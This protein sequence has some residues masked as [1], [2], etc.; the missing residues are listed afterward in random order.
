[1][2]GGGGSSSTSTS[3]S[4]S[5]QKWAQPLAKA[6]AGDVRN[7]FTANQPNLGMLTGKA[8]QMVDAGMSK[9]NLGLGNL[10][11]SRG[12]IGDQIGGAGFNNP[13]LESMIQAAR[14][15]VMDGVN[16]NFAGAGR[17][18]S[19]AHTGSMT[20]E[21]GNMEAGLRFNNYN[22]AAE[23]Q[24]QAAQMAEGAT[25]ADAAQSLAPLALAGQMPYMGSESMASSLGALFNGGT[26]K[27]TQKTG[28]ADLFS[29]LLGAGAQVGSA[30]ILA[31][32]VRLKDNVILSHVEPDGLPVYHWS[33]TGQADRHTGPMAQ[34]VAKYR[35]W[36]LGPE[37][38]GYMT[39]RPEA[40]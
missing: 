27:S 7:V 13:Y 19:G 2:S 20:R 37:I 15:G 35:P 22:Q 17:Y 30:A 40:L 28:G 10:G 6:G 11:A 5:A 34:D 33:Y 14:G 16:G 3:I 23:R 32:D 24:M 8:N 12:Y 26:S 1:M 25:Q 29:T 36:A 4:G 9:Y 31:S 38:G 21:L 39:I 18:G